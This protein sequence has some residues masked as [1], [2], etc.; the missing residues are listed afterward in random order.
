MDVKKFMAEEAKEHAHKSL[1]RPMSHKTKKVSKKN[2][3]VRYK[4]VP[5]A[6]GKVEKVAKRTGKDKI[7]KSIKE[8][9]EGR[10]H[11]G[12]KKGPL[13]KSKAQALAI[14]YAEKR[15]ASKKNK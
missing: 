12:S 15:K 5:K 9:A 14:G 4:S 2:K 6:N 8:F 10:L 3:K 13:V 7:V 1:K 11:S